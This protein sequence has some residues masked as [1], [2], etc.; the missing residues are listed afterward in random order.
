MFD[1]AAV[2]TADATV[3]TEPAD[4][5]AKNTAD[6]TASEA[7]HEVAFV[8]PALQNSKQLLSG[9]DKV[10]EVVSLQ[11][12]Q[13]P[14]KQISDYLASHNNISALH[15]FSH[16]TPGNV[17]L[18]NTVLAADTLNE[19]AQQLESWKQSLTTDADILLYGCDVAAGSKGE[20]FIT[21]L[22][23][24]TGADVAA[25]TDPTGAAAKGGDW[26]LEHSTGIIEATV[27]NVAGFDALM[28]APTV[29]TTATAMTVIEPSTLNAAGASSAT[30][31]GW[32][33]TD[34]GLNSS[35]I[36]VD[37]TVAD[38]AKGT[39]SNPGGAS[40]GVVSSITGGFHYIGTPGNAQTW[41]NQLVF[42]AA[43]V[44]LG[45]TSATTSITVLVT[46][47]E[48]TPLT[49]TKS[50]AVTI[51]PS[52][53][54]V[55]VP[56]GS[57]TVIEGSAGTAVTAGALAASDPEVTAGTQSTAQIVYRLTDLPAYGY[58]TLSGG[59]I[60]LGSIFTQADVVANSLVYTH[61]GSGDNQN[62]PDSFGVSVNDGATPQGSSDTATVAISITPVN[63]APTASGS[64]AVYEGQPGNAMTSG[65]PQSIVG[66]FI[67]ATGGGDP[68]TVDA[69]LTVKLTSLTGHGTLNFNGTAV[70]NGVSQSINRAITI[71][72]ITTGSGF[73]FDYANRSGLTYANDGI[74]P[75]GIPPNDSFN[76]SVTDGGGGLGSGSAKTTSATVNIN[77]HSVNDD[78]VWVGAS[79]LAA[80]VTVAGPTA[81]SGDDYRV[82]LT[83][84]ML[85]ATDVDSTDTEITF[86]VTQIPVD[87][88]LLLNGVRLVAGST[89]T[90]TDVRAGSLVYG[91]TALNISGANPTDQF[92][93]EV[94][95]NAL[96]LRWD[97]NGEDFARTGG[98]YN[99]GTSTSPLT[100]K[101]F[102]LNL[103]EAS[104]APTNNGGTG[105]AADVPAPTKDGLAIEYVG[106]KPNAPVQV[107]DEGG[108]ATIKNDGSVVMLRYSAAGASTAQIVYTVTGFGVNGN[109]WNGQL[110]KSGTAMSLY[111]TFTQ[112]DVN[113]NRI[114]FQHNGGEDFEQNFSFQVSAGGMNAG[115]PRTTNG[116]F[117]FYI[118]PVND[119]PTTTGSTDI[120]IKEGDTVNV[121]TAHLSFGDPDDATSEAYLENDPTVVDGVGD[122]FA[123]NNGLFGGNPLRF[124]IAV[125][126]THGSLQW[127]DTGAGHWV[128]ITAADVTDSTLFNTNIITGADLTTRL[129]YVHNGMEDRSDSF[130]VISRD[131]R[132]AE[133]GAGTVAVV[134]TNVN[135]APEIAADPTKTDPTAVGRASNNIGGV[136]AND[137]LTVVEEGGFT[138]ITK[139]MLQAYDPDSTSQQVQ[140][141]ITTA[142]LQG[143]MAYSTNGTTFATIGAGSSFSQAQVALGYIY[144]MQDGTEPSSSGYPNTPD[145]KFTFTLADG[146]KEQT[147]N[148]FW[149]YV[150]PTNDPPTVSAPAGPVRLDS[151]T[152]SLNPVPGFS[153]DDVDLA[154]LASVET[155]FLQVTVRL[156]QQNGTPFASGDYSDVAIGCAASG[157]IADTDK[158]GDH[159]YLTLRGTKAQINTALAGLTVT[160]ANDK[161][162]IYQVQIIADDRVRDDAGAF[163]DRDSST[164]GS[165]TGA[166]GGLLNQTQTPPGA[167]TVILSTEYDWYSDLVPTSGLITG[168][169]AA[170]TVTVWASHTNDLQTLTVPGAQTPSEDTAFTFS[171]AAGNRIQIADAE[172]S[173]FGLPVK[174]TLAVGQGTLAAGTSSGVT[175]TG[176][177]TATL[178]LSGKV[179]D[180]QTLLNN[181][182]TYTGNAQY[183]DTDTMTVTL[184]ED[185]AAIGGDVGSGSVKNAN[186]V[187]TVSLD[188]V[189]VNDAPAV[190]MPGGPVAVGTNVAVAIA[191][192]TISDT[193]DITAGD[194]ATIQTGE[195]DFVQAT[196]R[197][198]DSSGAP[199]A[200]YTGVTFGIAGGATTDA[201]WTGVAKPLV[202]RGTLSQVNTALAG[203]TVTMTGDRNAT[204]K[205]QV[206]VDDRLRAADGVLTSGADGGA[207]NQ[208]EGLPAVPASDAFYS[209]P[210][211][212]PTATATSLYNIV[213]GTVNLYA[214]SSND[215]PTNTLPAAITVTE[216]STNNAVMN[217]GQYI[218]VGDTDDFGANLTVVLTATGGTMTIGDNAGV[219]GDNATG[220]TSLTLSGNKTNLNSVLQSL[221]FSPTSNLHG[222]SG[223][224]NIRVV[225]TDT[226]LAGSGA[227][228]TTGNDDLNIAITTVNDRPTA[229]SNVTLDAITEDTTPAGVAI[230]GLAFGYSDATDN[231]SGVTNATTGISGSTTETAFSYIA[232]VGDTGYE[233]AQGSWQVS[234]GGVGW[235]TIPDSGLSTTTAL[236]FPSARNIRFV[237]AADYHGTPGTLSVRLADNSVNMTANISTNATQTCDLS[238]VGGT[239]TTGAWNNTN[240]TIGTTVTNVNDRPIV[241]ATTLTAT[242]EDHAGPA[243]ATVSTLFANTFKDNTDNQG[244]STANVWQNAGAAITGGGNAATNIGGLA[245]VANAANAVTEGIWQYKDNTGG[246]WLSVPTSG[247]ADS[248]A[249]VIPTSYSLRF[250]PNVANYNGTPGAL[251]IRAADLSGPAQ[252]FNTNSDI[253]GTLGDQ[254]SVWSTTQTL[255]TS[256]TAV[257]DVPSF[258]KGDDQTV[259]EDA[260]AK[261]VNGWATALN[262]GPADE[263]GQTLNFIVSNNN[264]ALFSSQPAIDASGNL[265]YTPAANA[266]GSATVTVQI[267][268]TGGIANG[269]VDTSATQTFIINVTAVNDAPVASGSSTLLAVAEDTVA[270]SIT[271]NTVSNLFTARFNDSTDTFTGGS[272][273]NTLAGIAIVGNTATAGQ[274][275]WEYYNGTSWQAVGSPTAGSPLLVSSAHSLR[276]VPVT[277]FNGVPGS[278]NVRLID[279][280]TTVTTGSTGPDLSN[281]DNYGG[282]T[283]ISASTV[284]LG[285]SVTAINDAPV[286]TGSTTLS[287]VTED[288]PSASNSGALI[289]NL[290]N[291]VGLYSDAT[292]TVSGGSTATAL[293][294]IAITGNASTSGQGTWEYS[295]D[296]TTWNSIATSVSNNSALV[297]AAGTKLHFQPAAN[298]NGTPGS[299]TVRTSDG[300]GFVAST[301]NTDYKDVSVN[302]GTTGWSSGTVSIITAITA[303]NDAPT[304]TAATVTLAAINEDQATSVSDPAIVNPGNSVSNLFTSAF[305]D[306]TDTVASGSSANTLAGVVIVGN[307]ASDV[308]QGVWQYHDGTGWH[309]VG[310]VSISNGLYVASTDLLRF[311]PVANFNGP[312]T[313]LTV[314][315]ADDSTNTVTTGTS[316]IDVS[317]DTTKSGVTTRYSNSS[318]A[319]TLNTS[320]TAINDAPTRSDASAATLTAV[321]EDVGTSAPGNTVHNLF[322]G[323]FVDSADTVTGGTSANNLAGVVIVANTANPT[324]EGSWQYRI[325]AGTWTDVGT[326]ETN[327]GLF[328]AQGDSL[329]FVPVADYNG[330]PTGLIVRL[331][332]NSTG[333]LPSSGDRS[334]DVSD[335][336][337]K[338]GVTTRYSNSSNAVTLN[339]SVTAVA[340]IVADSITTTEDKAITFNSISGVG[341]G[342]ADNFEG[343]PT[344]TA[345]TQGMHGAVTFLADGS[346]TY[347]PAAGYSGSDSFTYTVTSPTGVTETATISVTVNAIYLPPAPPEP[348][349]APPLG[350]PLPSSDPPVVIIPGYYS[351]NDP[352]STPLESLS[353]FVDYGGGVGGGIGGGDA[354]DNIYGYDLY[355][356]KNPSSQEMLVDEVGSFN[357]PTGTFRHS[358]GNAKITLEAS[359]A[360]GSPLP[361]WL[362]FDPDSGR[363][364]GK[365]PKGTGGAMDIKVLARD[366]RG[367][368]AV[369][370]FLLHITELE[371]NDTQ[372]LKEPQTDSNA[373]GIDSYHLKPTDQDKDKPQ[374]P[375]RRY[376]ALGRSSLSDQFKQQQL[377]GR[378]EALLET[379]Q[380]TTVRLQ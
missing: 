378:N 199:I 286:S 43:D 346:L 284:A 108:T 307:T 70:I 354:T 87:G 52:N 368:V 150:K 141:R 288:I 317:D 376:A 333:T 154:T 14:L 222:A 20:A 245:I 185:Q 95:D 131:R 38:T 301:T 119:N 62:A 96:S 258:T 157:A 328:V 270:G 281:S 279:S 227:N 302:G 16:G 311:V 264:S 94:V 168:N 283:A 177:G 8:D 74:D 10:I 124:R 253:S 318:N 293:A 23:I 207:K 97:T 341:G 363:F 128:N 380:R 277:D 192:V 309:S 221:T 355:L 263:S 183:N 113:N 153:I 261:T 323:K 36:T 266:N 340:D 312:P 353:Q 197:L 67:T 287:S 82:V 255:T 146:D 77:V 244:V 140:Y 63:Q 18:G 356:V 88:N 143:R 80:T 290:I 31:S 251:T 47:G 295:T 112:D 322:N 260:G 336:T 175:I 41:V 134:I 344:V 158:N 105:V 326:V 330:A 54:P 310:T 314:R 217:G 83:A 276:F 120:L 211:N 42:T 64:G 203:L 37:V 51:T 99:N 89:F 298:W 85:Q 204:Y 171:Q 98:V 28:A 332:D 375:K 35:D 55:L 116:V 169:I 104:V 231:Q 254:T 17:T 167:P 126:P 265:T 92:Q 9:L 76:I 234:D 91:Q 176:S 22:S 6:A 240:R 239:G 110:L 189:A 49:A 334:I 209:D 148:E 259:N 347:T 335:D 367:N 137:P 329:R 164:A 173:A 256:V 53:D 377:R 360:D 218:Q 122:N 73:V 324:T 294:G 59:R 362:T 357:L 166:N 46:D 273:A 39:L 127:D 13:D 102:T 300:T 316:G 359:L 194:A 135:D 156:L 149:I 139:E 291:T 303:V 11:S 71:A 32:T 320:V 210:V 56:D 147:G 180:I 236:I 343:T 93:F 313:G 66:N 338:S 48:L 34:D 275:S 331:A 24:L 278:L 364:T 15:L 21:Q 262:K 289:S 3:K 84:A 195:T 27:L 315:L 118:T 252:D 117:T 371:S 170:N 115:V 232:I 220:Q 308:T 241:S 246:D 379:L 269:G 61:T 282:T 202:L 155:N 188:L 191:G 280:S 26:D 69:I 58:L 350:T 366:D 369:A 103:A 230:S 235:I 351:F 178:V 337:A 373:E 50:L 349:G 319:V 213:A 325:G 305:T 243:G 181:G 161:D 223:V 247:L 86:A 165:Q 215:A 107:F 125:L 163:T 12:G 345:V 321:L 193:N 190:T 130:Q 224:A 272:S 40:G 138:Q 90:M 60:G 292:D 297:L 237:P 162:A 250:L 57:L 372:T 72:D 65:V 342:S 257:N 101:T 172:S 186:E 182:F 201:T 274:G 216:D 249:F 29:S 111:S 44:E 100:T 68:V 45:N 304:R 205:L 296:G 159:D 152:P 79:T 151:T 370:Q 174:L 208:Q 1:A 233:A 184:D 129:R 5:A 2:A 229:S 374:Q 106:A 136:P 4:S 109:S 33:I 238:T 299:L 365:P 242:T 361:E 133:S 78:P 268:D 267:H 212:T 219:T 271:G 160:F 81:D 132:G 114:T 306:V 7:R 145:D 358:S 179:D 121:T 25:S 339:T 198:L 200:V 30:L 144:Y 327:N 196:V 187:K 214:S 285:T 352:A 228:R 225:T 123:L 19:H 348:P 142:P 248:S 226:A 206:L 75:G